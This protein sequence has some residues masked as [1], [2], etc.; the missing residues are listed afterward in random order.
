[1]S[2]PGERPLIRRRLGSTDLRAAWEEQAGLWV[3]WARTPGHD[4]YWRFHRDLFLELVPPPGV[5]TV[6]VGCGEGRVTRE[7]RGRGHRVVG[8][9][10]SPSLVRL[11]QEADPAGEYRL[12][13]AARLPLAAG[14]ADLVVAFMSLHDIEDGEGAVREAARVLAPRG[15]MCF[16]IVHPVA[17]AGHFADDDQFVISASYLDLR[18]QR[19]PLGTADVPSFHRPLAWYFEALE[20]A[21]FLVD[22]VRELATRRRAPGRFPMF[23]HVRALKL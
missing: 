13:D 18:E 3:D 22:V 7:L 11:A 12:G 4:S 17:S 15:R 6:D 10:V 9:D 16:A 23:L 19:F 14:E 5:L 20:R 2:D 21:G 1:M 8:V